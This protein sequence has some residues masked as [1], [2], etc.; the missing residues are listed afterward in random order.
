MDNYF[1]S[2]PLLI[3][4][5]ARGIYGIVTIRINRIEIPS[6]LKN[7][8]AFRRVAQGHMEWAMHDFRGVSCIMW[9]DKC[10]ILLLS[11]HAPPIRAPYEVRDTV[12]RRHGAVTNEIFTSPVLLEYTKYI[13]G[14]DVAVQLWASYTCHKQSHKWWHRVFWFLVDTSIMNMYIM[15]LHIC[16]TA[17]N[18]IT[19][20]THLQFKTDLCSE[21][22][23]N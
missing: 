12:P 16:R 2:I 18:P 14:V 10:P 19:P 22:F 5:A 20:K 7:T 6:Y 11:T 3:D 17:T 23:R 1:T 4:L 13:R 9:K 8:R 15:Y 21:L